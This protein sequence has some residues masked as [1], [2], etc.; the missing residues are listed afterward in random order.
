MRVSHAGSEMG[1]YKR[2]NT[3]LKDPGHRRR[4]PEERIMTIEK[5]ARN[6]RESGQSQTQTCPLFLLKSE[7]TTSLGFILLL[8]ASRQSLG[9]RGPSRTLRGC[10][11]LQSTDPH[12]QLLLI[13]GLEQ[14]L[15]A[16]NQPVKKSQYKIINMNTI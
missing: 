7:E 4:I 14:I 1:I 9:A 2:Y 8:R 5:E 13:F 15:R 11:N 16:T 6:W 12:V 10:G 3:S